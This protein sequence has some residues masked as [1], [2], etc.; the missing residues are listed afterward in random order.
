MVRLLTIQFITASATAL[1]INGSFGS[2]IRRNNNEGFLPDLKKIYLESLNIAKTTGIVWL[3][4]ELPVRINEK[5]ETR[6]VSVKCTDKK[7]DYINENNAYKNIYSIAGNNEH[8]MSVFNQMFLPRY[9]SV[10]VGNGMYCTI[11]ASAKKLIPLSV[12]VNKLEAVKKTEYIK[13]IFLQV[14]TATSFLHNRK[15]THGNINL[16]NILIYHV[17]PKSKPRAILANLEYS[18]YF[19][20]DPKKMPLGGAFNYR[21]PE[22]SSGNS[23]V[24]MLDA[25]AIGVSLYFILIGKIPFNDDGSGKIIN[26]YFTKVYDPKTLKFSSSPENMINY[27]YLNTLM[28]QYVEKN[29]AWRK[30]PEDTAGS[31][32]GFERLFKEIDDYSTIIY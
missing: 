24:R 21:A 22:Y 16:D 26:E 18:V 8:H 6:P 14:V 1:L 27:L 31:S 19:L 25:W 17:D 20:S 5:V 3:E 7:A 2:V 10:D 30:V 11:L 28:N 29:V 9:D 12:Y 32:G 4:K 13:Q 23:D 15:M